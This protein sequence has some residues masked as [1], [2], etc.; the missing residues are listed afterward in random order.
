MSI[1]QR[2]EL[3]YTIEPGV[4]S[5]HI[6]GLRVGLAI[7]RKCRQCGRVSFPPDRF[8]RCG[9]ADHDWLTLSGHGRVL[10]ATSIGG[11]GTAFVHFDGADNSAVVRVINEEC[12]ERHLAS[13]V[14][15]SCAASEWPTIDVATR[16]ELEI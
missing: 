5:P 1:T 9:V 12:R 3:T 4:L 16:L 7:A 11:R 13:I 14:A 6:E 2:L 10:A 8:C 15:S